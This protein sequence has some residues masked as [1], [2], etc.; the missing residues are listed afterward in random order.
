MAKRRSLE[1]FNDE[2]PIETI[3]EMYYPYH[4]MDIKHFVD[5]MNKLR[6]SKRVT[7]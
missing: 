5:N 4:E 3:V 7:L 1:E 2:V 6:R